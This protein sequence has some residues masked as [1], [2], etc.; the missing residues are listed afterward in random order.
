MIQQQ[1]DHPLAARQTLL[2]HPALVQRP[3]IGQRC[4]HVNRTEAA[5]ITG[6]RVLHPVSMRPQTRS[7]IRLPVYIF[8]AA[9]TFFVFGMKQLFPFLLC[10]VFILANFLSP[11]PFLHGFMQDAR[12]PLTTRQDCTRIN[13]VLT[14]RG[15]GPRVSKSLLCKILTPGGGR[16]KGISIYLTA[17][18]FQLFCKPK[19]IRK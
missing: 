8:L 5:S 15:Q 19:M 14:S 1:D 6:S 13:R 2:T 16:A 4:S 9:W 10:H 18:P 11:L 3:W 17:L 12:G 7:S